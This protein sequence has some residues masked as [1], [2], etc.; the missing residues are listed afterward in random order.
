MNRLVRGHALVAVGAI[1]A[2]LQGGSAMAA[3]PDFTVVFPAG[4]ACEFEMRLDGFGGKG[5]FREFRDR[6]GQVVRTFDHVTGLVLRFTHTSTDA[7]LSVRLNGSNAHTSDYAPDGSFTM[8]LTGHRLVILF[9]TDSPPGP[10]T[11]LFNGQA[12]FLVEPGDV[13][14]LVSA[15]GKETDIC[16][17][18]A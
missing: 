1:A 7:T 16:A 13:Y 10:S 15:K 2:T 12:T 6:D 3:D 18:L 14:T 5:H 9:P 8:K 17:A 11:T 4:L